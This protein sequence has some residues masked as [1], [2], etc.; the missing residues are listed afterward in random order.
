[1]EKKTPPKYLSRQTKVLSR[2]AYFCH[3][4]RHVCCDKHVFVKTKLVATKILVAA[5]ANDSS[6]ISIY[7]LVFCTVWILV[8]WEHC[9]ASQTKAKHAL[10]IESHWDYKAKTQLAEHFQ[11][12]SLIFRFLFNFDLYYPLEK[13]QPLWSSHALRRPEPLKHT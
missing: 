9:T 10:S 2:Q 12:K 5:P 6:Q 4:K 1:M 7:W 8:W 11:T 3:D 13:G